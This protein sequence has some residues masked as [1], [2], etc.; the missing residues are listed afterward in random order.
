MWGA[1]SGPYLVIPILGPATLRDGVGKVVDPEINPNLYVIARYGGVW[2]T[3]GIAGFMAIDEAG[4]LDDVLAGSLDLYPR[5]R[6][7][8]LQKRASELGDAI[9]VTI[10]P[11]TEPLQYD[12]GRQRPRPRQLRPRRPRRSAASA[13]AAPKPAVQ[14]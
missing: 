5:L 6:S 7:L 13:K 8:Y 9:G 12:P 2:P 4:G 11:Q 14:Q 10:N 3:V 1:D